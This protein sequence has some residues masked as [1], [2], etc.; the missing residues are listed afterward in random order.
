MSDLNTLAERRGKLVADA[1]ELLGRGDGLSA[2]EIGQ[3]EQMIADSAEL[4]TQMDKIRDLREKAEHETRALELWQ[5]AELPAPNEVGS[6]VP[7]VTRAS[8]QRDEERSIR[9]LVNQATRYGRGAVDL[10]LASTD[11]E[12]RMVKMGVETRDVNQA[13]RFGL[14]PA[15]LVNGDTETRALNIGT[16]NKGGFTVPTITER[17]WYEYLL[18][19]GGVRNAGAEVWTTGHGDPIELTTIASHYTPS[20]TLEKAESAEIAATEP[21]LGQVTLNAY[22]YTARIDYTNELM[23]DTAIDINGLVT[24]S[25]A[26]TIATQT[27]M[28]FTNGTAS[29]MP[30]GIMHSPASG[31]TTTTAASNAVVAGELVAMYYGLDGDILTE[32]NTGWMM[33]PAT[34]GEIIK[35]KDSDGRPL[36]QPTY[37]GDAPEM[38]L[39]RPVFWNPQTPKITTDNAICAVVGN[40]NRAY[41]IR[42]AARVT[43]EAST[44]LRFDHQETVFIASTRMDGQIRDA[45]ALRWLKAKA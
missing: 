18:M 29:S 39:G 43:I 15:N 6:V 9:G 37:Y 38:I 27:E 20:G 23:M 21:T 5:G 16:N 40:F 11:V 42:Q 7:A 2:E 44:H 4:R 19:I 13:A 41:I 35:L 28:R 1:Q 25:L 34:Y 17:T 3:A 30:K 31:S 8:V 36:F 32:N 45:T 26:R 10:D 24:S 22:K 33:H 12:Y 14:T